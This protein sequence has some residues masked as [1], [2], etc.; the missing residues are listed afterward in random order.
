MSLV[1]GLYRDLKAVAFK[2]RGLVYINNYIYHTPIFI[3]E[4]NQTPMI[5]CLKRFLSGAERWY[6][7]A[8]SRDAPIAQWIERGPPEAEAQVRVLVGAPESLHPR[9]PGAG[10]FVFLCLIIVDLPDRKA[11][12]QF[13]LRIVLYGNNRGDCDGQ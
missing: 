7:Q 8:A 1:W 10:I 5:S 2:Y 11:Y 6:N 4:P 13:E 9:P 3:F 12:I